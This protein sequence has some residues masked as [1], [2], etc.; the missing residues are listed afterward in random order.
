YS[1]G[2]RVVTVTLKHWLWS[3]GTPITSRDVT[4]WINLLK[5]NKVNYYNYVP[6]DFPD[7]L[8]S[9]ATRGDDTVVLRLKK[10]VTPLWFTDNELPQIVPLPQHA[11]D[12]TS[13]TGPVG[14]YDETSSGALAVWKF[15]NAESSKTSTYG[16]SSL[17]KV[18]SG[19]Y[20]IDSLTP[21]GR[22]VFSANASYSGTKPRIATLIW[23]P[24]T[25]EE[26]EF[27]A[28]LAGQVDYGYVPLDD[29]PTI[30]RVTAA[31]YRIA[32]WPAWS[33]N[34]MELNFNNPVTGPLVH[35]LYLR[36][37]LEHL[38]DQTGYV[39]AF[40]H[41]YGYPT[42][43]PVPVQPANPFATSAERTNPYPYDPSAAAKLLAAHGWSKGSSGVLSCTRPG[44]GS[45]DCGAGI[46]AGSL[47]S[48]NLM[49]TSGSTVFQDE[50]TTFQQAAS[51]IGVRIDLSSAPFGTVIDHSLPCTPKQSDCSGQIQY[52]GQG[53]VFEPDYYPSGEN[54]FAGGAALNSS[55][56]DDP[57]ANTLIE[58][59]ITGGGLGGYESYISKQVPVLW[60]P[61]S[62]SQISAI[63]TS[64]LGVGAQNPI[65]TTTPETWYFGS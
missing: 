61:V 11:W 15:L 51:G 49:Y 50:A 38:I 7:D 36:Q 45:S 14:N 48:F 9:V 25:S 32:A 60:M 28:V 20:E 34:Y 16:T 31:G 65:L 13:A 4:F 29:A 21:Q 64:L 24:Y 42:Y 2:D 18:V 35:Q 26:A 40:L 1:D 27:D 23:L 19:P 17:W 59:S 63:K 44:T 56:Y 46:K 41:G 54:F 3:D 5:A 37:A 6:G 57:M 53:W 10:P 43:G 8:A 62:D 55:N 33:I 30:V 12:R 39:T 52:W 58:Q 22:A 47:L